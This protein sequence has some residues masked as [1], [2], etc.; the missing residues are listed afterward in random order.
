MRK[1]ILLILFMPFQASGQ[2]LEN[3]ESGNLVNWVQSQDGHWLADTT[4]G[5][6]GAFSLHHVFDNP[7]AGTDQTGIPVK[8]FHP[9]AGTAKWS[10]IIRYGYDPSASNNWAVFL[11]S[12][13]DPATML[14]GAGTNGFA[15]GVN[16]TGYDDTL[17][18]W[19]VN[20]TSINTVV[21]SRINWQ[22]DI[23]TSRAVKIIAERSSEGAWNMAVYHL[24]GQIINTSSGFDAT[25][26]ASEWFGVYY[27]YSSTRDK[28]LWLDDINIEGSFYEDN[29]APVVS[30][31]KV[32]G[33]NSIE[34]SFSE[35]PAAGTI[36][37]DNFSLN[38][39]DIKSVSVLKKSAL[40]FTI[41]FI[42]RFIN[43]SLNRLI[44]NQICDKTGNCMDNIQITFTPVL[45]EPGDVAITELMVDPLPVVS[46][47]AKE[48]LEISNRTGF[49]FNMKNWRLSTESRSELFPSII[50]PADSRLIICSVYDTISFAE[51]GPVAGLK[52]FP[53]LNDTHMTLSVSDSSGNLI[54]GIEYSSN[55][56][57]D[58]I[59]A[60]GGWALEMIDT[61]FPFYS[62][63]N[64]SASKARKGGTPGKE[65]SVSKNNQDDHFQGI[66]NVFPDDS[67]SI[68]VLFSE[69]LFAVDSCT[70]FFINEGKKIV[71][72]S[73]TDQLHRAFRIRP[74]NPLDRGKLYSLSVS[75]DITDFAGNRIE[76]ASFNFGLPENSGRGDIL[77]NELLFNPLP[78]DPD[79]IEFYNNSGKIIDA[80]RLFIVTV[81]KETGDTSSVIQLSEEKRCILPGAYYSVTTDKERIIKRYISSDPE[82]IFQI[83]PMPSMNDDSGHL[84][85][86]NRELDMIDEVFYDDKM[87]YSLLKEKEGV[88]L[89]KIRQQNP[90][91]ERSG[92]HSA[93]GS[94]GWGTPGARNSIEIRDLQLVEGV[95]L[96][97]TKI[98]PDNDGNE[99]VLVIGL[100]LKENGNVIS[101]TI[102]D[103]TGTIVRKLA[104][105]LL[106]GPET[107]IIW[108]GCADDGK[109]VNNGIYIVFIEMY[110]S[111]GKVNKWKNV[112]TVIRN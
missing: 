24:N 40:T 94:S 21:S 53:S 58:E 13:S 79:Y 8:N 90:S 55:W 112:C 72:I 44:I 63:G 64:W 105:K 69:T 57:G 106:A 89:E 46:L 84:I 62:E 95:V 74:D 60:T 34:I 88:A 59:R 3:F 27:K 68:N 73:Q 97:S 48:Y 17:R 18:L 12:D 111:S 9:E 7:N 76:K 50:I 71:T 98:T 107:A 83:A 54:H 81:N 43:K 38:S 20:G 86:F 41:S 42:D 29:E 66:L 19:K 109:L 104:D 49:S 26:F 36:L 6:S 101:V 80:S 47:P 82:Y 65:N 70:D 1:V 30:G 11:M 15:L 23:G 31:Y 51:Y 33:M 100:N 102:F 67:G 16:I 56:Y 96:S 37:P 77:F 87:H 2:I 25:L 5:I 22:N 35:E 10:F 99:D 61:G 14:P 75:D 103:E 28:L 45:V 78:G 32:T 4:S 91:S 92:W 39:T 52:Q 108:D 110:N 93:S 85:L